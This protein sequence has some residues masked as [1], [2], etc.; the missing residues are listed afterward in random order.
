MS[1]ESEGHSWT[2]KSERWSTQL[3]KFNK[4]NGELHF[5]SKEFIEGWAKENG[6]ELSVIVKSNTSS[7]TLFSLRKKNYNKDHS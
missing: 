5:F 1:D 3:M 7:N 2:K 6:F 4:T